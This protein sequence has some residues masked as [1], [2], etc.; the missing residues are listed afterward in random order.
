MAR[1]DYFEVEQGESA[2]LQHLLETVKK[3]IADRRL[4]LRP[5][6][7]DFD[8]VRNGYVTKSQ[9]LRVLNQF[10]ILANDEFLNVLLKCYVDKGSLHEVN[11][12]KFCND[13]DGQ[14]LVTK[15]INDTYADKFAIPQAK[16]F[17]KPYIYNTIPEGLDDV[18]QK[19]QRKVKEERIRIGEFLRDFDRLRCGS[20]A[21][22]QFRIGLN[23][24]KIPL[25]QPEYQML[26]NHFG[27]PDKQNFMMWKD[28]SDNIDRVFNIKSLEKNPM[29]ET[30]VPLKTT[31]TSREKMNQTE[32]ALAEKVIERFKYFCL[33]TRL[34]VKQFFQD[35]DPLGRYKVTPKQFRQVLV[36]VRFTLSDDEFKATGKYFLTEDGYMDYADFINFT[37]PFTGGSVVTNTP[38]ASI[39]Y[40]I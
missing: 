32:T 28:F 15:I 16:E 10:D 34:Y 37:S 36:T 3:E 9:F 5:H 21:N 2:K 24:A 29:S 31:L 13:V 4:L 30:I 25:S 40:L 38:H 33:A 19:I 17:S 6:F 11:Y 39:F 35:W 12:Y 8:R 20:I 22:S 27:C 23:M 7:Q 14:D 26:I 1:R 18:I